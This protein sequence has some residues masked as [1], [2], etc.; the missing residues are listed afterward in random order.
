MEYYIQFNGQTIGPM[1][2]EQ[3][4]AYGVTRDTPVSANGGDWK[5]LFTYPELMQYASRYDNVSSGDSRKLVCGILALL[6]GGFGIQYFLIG[7]T[8]AGIINIL[9]SIVTCG[10]WTIVNFVQGIMILCMSEEE[11]RR[12]FVDSTSTFPVF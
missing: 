8:T 4:G 7:K 5:P 1:T 3:I 2:K 9:L 11:W 6:I 12:K 10:L